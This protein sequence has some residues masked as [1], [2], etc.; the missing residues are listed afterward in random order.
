MFKLKGRGPMTSAQKKL[1]AACVL[2]VV[3]LGASIAIDVF[4]GD[5]LPD[6][7]HQDAV[8]EL[9][10]REPGETGGED[11]EA[12]DGAKSEL[13]SLDNGEAEDCGSFYLTNSTGTTIEL[14]VSAVSRALMLQFSAAGIVDYAEATLQIAAVGDGH[15]DLSY[16][17]VSDRESFRFVR[18]CG[19]SAEDGLGVA[20]FGDIDAWASMMPLDGIS[21]SDVPLLADMRAQKQAEEEARAEAEARASAEAEPEAAEE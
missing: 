1:L 19:E 4:A 5:G 11:D 8:G 15:G 6:Q 9:Q 16:Y 18:V 3:I 21:E 14:P 7:P 13:V 12:E 10:E 17:L 20:L 2:L